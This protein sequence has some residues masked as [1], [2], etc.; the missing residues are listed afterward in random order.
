MRKRCWAWSEGNPAPHFHDVSKR[1][2]SLV[3]GSLHQQRHREVSSL[4]PLCHLLITEWTWNHINQH[5]LWGRGSKARFSMLETR[6]WLRSHSAQHQAFLSASPTLL[7]QGWSVHAHLHRGLQHCPTV[8]GRVHYGFHLALEGDRSALGWKA[9]SHSGVGLG[10]A[11]PPAA[12]QQR[13]LLQ[14]HSSCSFHSGAQQYLLAD[15]A[16]TTSAAF[17]TALHSTD[18]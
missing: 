14:A 8:S 16:W 1:L 13:S 2:E 4:E 17:P 9:S 7:I 18:N 5:T 6:S 12:L 10:P 3:T 11:N 15:R